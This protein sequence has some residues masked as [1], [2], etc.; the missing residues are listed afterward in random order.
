M[1]N[2]HRGLAPV[3]DAAWAQIDEEAARTLKRHLAARRVVD[4][5]GPKGA[6]FAAVD[7]GHARSIAAPGD[8]VEALQRVVSAVVELRVP[9]ELAREAIDDV[10]RGSKDS[11]WAPLKDAARRI[12]FAED[13][14]VFDGYAAAGIQGIRQSTSH[15]VLALPA[16][17]VRYPAAVARAVS[18]LRLAGV[19]GSCALVLGAGPWVAVNAAS[20]HG[21]PVIEH[22]ERLVDG[23]IVWAPA[24][25]GAVLVA[26]RGGDFALHVG[27]D[28]A[29]GYLGHTATAVR[30][31]LQESFTFVPLTAEASVT[32]APPALP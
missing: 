9:F 16:D 1:N 2:L 8:G 23:G 18:E 31:Y 25:D 5:E 17:V 27:E 26:T 11:D 21:H 15:P 14:A 6:G 28:F 24:I 32:L 12:A 19:E 3:S 4:V 13:R 22:I 10:E 7:R 30:L 20:D 29:I